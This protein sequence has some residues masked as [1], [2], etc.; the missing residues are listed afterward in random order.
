[1][2]PS[3]Q[4]QRL[5]PLCHHNNCTAAALPESKG[6]WH[7]KACQQCG[8]VYLE[9]PPAYEAL[10]TDFAWEKTS[11]VEETRRR[12][13]RPTRK[14]LSNQW[15]HFRQKVLKRDKLMDLVRKY[16]PAGKVLDIGCGGG[17]TLARL[18]GEGHIPH[19]IEISAALAREAHARAAPRGGQVVQANALEGTEAF[20]PN[21]FDGV[22]MSAFLEHEVHPGP[23][24]VG[25]LRVLKPG[26]HII[27]KVP[28]YGSLN[29][30]LMRNEWCGLRFPDHVNY[31]TPQS[32]RRLAQEN[33]YEIARF[34]LQ[35]HFPTSD[36]MWMVLRK[37]SA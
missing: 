31:F 22:L 16:I 6:G 35:D 17:G 4:L 30:K 15:K 5:C 23:L 9:N 8:T 11:A 34:R 26:G 27:I 1:M 3:R 33:G 36:N 25:L 13:A 19:G 24:L 29:R 7:L 18:P 21:T 10:V 2:A 12:E 37:P 20:A 28:N 14:A 32:L